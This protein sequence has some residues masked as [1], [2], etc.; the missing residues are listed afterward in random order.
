MLAS[1]H[2]YVGP[3]AHTRL[4]ASMKLQ[5]YYKKVRGLLRTS[6]TQTPAAP[7]SSEK[8]AVDALSD[9]RNRRLCPICLHEFPHFLRYNKRRAARCPGC[10]SLERHRTSWLYLKRETDLFRKPARLLHFAPEPFFVERIQRYVTIDH[11]KAS[12][13]PE[14]PT[15]GVDIQ[16]LPYPD[17]HFDVIYCSH[18]LEHVPD[19]RLALRE[20]AR[21]LKPD[22]VAMVLVPVRNEARTYEDPS[23]VSPEDRAKHFGQ[24]DHLRWYGRDFP[25]RVLEAQLSCE[26]VYYSDRFSPI[27]EKLYGL[28]P[29][30]FYICRHG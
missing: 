13:D 4:K 5:S 9:L 18:V 21:V 23:I 12:F 6:K 27:E 19:D 15:E 14:R 25:E 7:A 24:W 8:V 22:G 17:A 10:G 1:T 30:P 3:V 16:R 11:V 29:E 26:T 2:P 20:L 28:R